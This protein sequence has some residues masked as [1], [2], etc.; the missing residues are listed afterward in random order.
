MPIIYATLAQIKAAITDKSEAGAG[1]PTSGDTNLTR[2]ENAAARTIDLYVSSI[3]GRPRTFVAASDTTRTFH[4]LSDVIGTILYTAS[5]LAQT[6][7]TVTH[8]NTATTVVVST[9]YIL[10]SK[11]AP[12]VAPYTALQLI[13]GTSWT[14][15]T[16]LTP[17]NA[18]SITGRFAYSVTPP[19]DIVQATIQLTTSAWRQRHT[20]A[21]V[22]S[23]TVSMDGTL[24]FP[25]GLPK[26]VV[27]LLQPYLN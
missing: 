15:N 14:Y 12:H 17:V 1:F 4:A 22:Q 24:I 9:N 16:A 7:S 19:D 20:T 2:L 23:V 13:D 8:N 18:I 10:R 27:D 11:H 5:D 3:L 26:Q 21:N 25:D 6:P